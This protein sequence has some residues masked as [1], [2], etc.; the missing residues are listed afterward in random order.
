MLDQQDDD[1]LQ[2]DNPAKA[3]IDLFCELAPNQILEIGCSHGA[4][5]RLSGSSVP[6]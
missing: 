6:Q 1:Y 3:V 2:K 5:I 4:R